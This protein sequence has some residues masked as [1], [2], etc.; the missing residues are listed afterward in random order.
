MTEPHPPVVGFDLDMTLVDSRAGIVACMHHALELHGGS[1]S[2][3]QLAPLIGA[4]LRDN[5]AL[6]LPDDRVEAAMADYRSSYLVDAVP[7]TTAMPGAAELLDAIRERGGRVVVV[8][9]KV[10]PAI[11][12]VLE[13]VGLRPDAVAGDL[14]AEG[15]A[16]ALREHGATTYVGD[17]TGDMRAARAAGV[18]GIGVTTGPHD[19]QALREA[20]AS[21]V[22]A[23]LGEVL[24]QL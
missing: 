11:H 15:K 12:A 1:A 3:E 9:A 22:V 13:H 21:V 2:D 17:H 20:G 5:L 6:F 18:P 4:P 23:G 24:A 14:F 19:E 8:S 10:E 7:V 16:S